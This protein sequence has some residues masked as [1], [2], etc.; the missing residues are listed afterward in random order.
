MDPMLH[1]EVVED[2]EAGPVPQHRL[3]S[4]PATVAP[5]LAD[6]LVAKPLTLHS[7]R[8]MGDLPQLPSRRRVHRLWQPGR[9]VQRSVVPATLV[10][11]RRSGALLDRLTHH[12]H[13][14]EMN[15]ES[16]R[17]KESRQTASMLS[18]D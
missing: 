2:H 10:G 17:L 1:R 14:I 5:Q 18:P 11:G 7:T 13:I 8:S 16:Y 4:V 9:H 6:V 3:G 15:D 12:L